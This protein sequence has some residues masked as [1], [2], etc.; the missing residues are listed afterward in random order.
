MIGGLIGEDLAKA[1]EDGK[2]LTPELQSAINKFDSN[3][4]KIK[5]LI[6]K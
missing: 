4:D 2:K 5:E 6:S 1:T 3:K